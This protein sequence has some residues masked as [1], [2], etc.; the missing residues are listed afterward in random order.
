MLPVLLAMLPVLLAMLPVLLPGVCAKVIEAK[1][2]D[3]TAAEIIVKTKSI[4][5]TLVARE[6]ILSTIL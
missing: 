1:D 4:T 5:D 2:I 3:A 6:F